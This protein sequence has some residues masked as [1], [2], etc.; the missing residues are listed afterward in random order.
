MAFVSC[1]SQARQDTGGGSVVGMEKAASLR[2]WW[3][4]RAMTQFRM[5]CRSALPPMAGRMR[6]VFDRFRT[7]SAVK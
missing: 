5:S 6:T 7:W 3:L 4:P 2:T 1:A